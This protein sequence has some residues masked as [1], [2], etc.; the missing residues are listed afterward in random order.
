MQTFSL[1]GTTS[2]LL[3]SHKFTN[4]ANIKPSLSP[5][6]RRVFWNLRVLESLLNITFWGLNLPSHLQTCISLSIIKKIV[7][8]QWITWFVIPNFPISKTWKSTWNSVQRCVS[9]EFSY[10]FLFLFVFVLFL[11]APALRAVANFMI[12]EP[13]SYSLGWYLRVHRTG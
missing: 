1:P 5:L 12:G 4:L 8:D 9:Q 13:F 11:F 6:L 7:Q 10:C 3:L 2:F